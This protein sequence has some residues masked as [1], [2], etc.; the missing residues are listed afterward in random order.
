MSDFRIALYCLLPLLFTACQGDAG[1]DQ[2]ALR[3]AEFILARRPMLVLE[4]DGTLEKQFSGITAR[5]TSAGEIVVCDQ[6]SLAI[7]VFDSDGELLR[8]IARRG[9]G[10]GEL[11]GPPTIEVKA[12]TVLAFGVGPMSDTDVD[13]FSVSSGFIRRERLDA[14]NHAGVMSGKGYITDGH[15]MVQRGAGFAAITQLPAAGSLLPDSATYGILPAT[16]SGDRKVTWLPPIQTGSFVTFQWPGGPVPVSLTLLSLGHRTLTTAS[17]DQVWVLHTGS[18]QLTAYDSGG[19]VV[20]NVSIG[21]DIRPYDKDE[22]LSARDSA[23]ARARSTVDSL[24]ARASHDLS[25]LPH[26]MPLADRMVAGADGGIWLR[27]F[28]VLPGA[29]Q[30]F[31]A[32]DRAGNR[33]GM[34]TVPPTLEV[35]QFGSDFV[36]GIRR[37]EMDVESV[38]V[39]SLSRR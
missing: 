35:Q 25:V 37:D 34:L 39:Y 16:P 19:N 1:G 10:P 32:L 20:R 26:T 38:V 33:L 28:K 6:G 30:E 29:P 21:L 12:D 5:R 2:S 18:G 9:A 24:A 8:S 14:S 23:F 4:G 15:Y 11:R 3:T 7:H 27:L 17:S 13:V 36:L 22:L 31:L